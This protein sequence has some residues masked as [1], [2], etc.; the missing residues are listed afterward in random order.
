M[1]N[2]TPAMILDVMRCSPTSE[3]ALREIDQVAN[4]LPEEHSDLVMTWATTMAAQHDTLYALF[5]A[6][7]STVEHLSDR[8]LGLR[9]KDGSLPLRSP[10]KMHNKFFTYRRTKKI[11]VWEF[12][13]L[14]IDDEIKK[15]KKNKKI[16]NVT[17]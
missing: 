12:V 17:E 1:S 11:N 14:P 3:D 13:D 16:S 9:I 5:I 15:P 4:T 10:Q 8:D 2:I 6:D 7:I